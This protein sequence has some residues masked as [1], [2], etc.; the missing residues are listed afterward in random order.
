MSEH[1]G[2]LGTDYID[3]LGLK[4]FLERQ[5]GR[6]KDHLTTTT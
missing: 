3:Y 2:W 4:D 6:L 5:T 1:I